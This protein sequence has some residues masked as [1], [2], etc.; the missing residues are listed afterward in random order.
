MIFSLGLFIL[1]MG[2]ALC[3]QPFPT[4]RRAMLTIHSQMTGPFPEKEPL[5]EPTFDDMKQVAFI[6]ANITEFLDVQPEKALTVASKHMG[7]L[8]ARNVPKLTEMMLQE[9]PQIRN[10]KMMMRAYMFLVD[11]LE[12]VVKETATMLKKNQESLRK[13]LEAAKKSEEALNSILQS[14]SNDL[15]SQEFLVYLDSEIEGQDAKSPMKSLLVTIKLRI[16]DEIGKSMGID[17]TILPK[18]AS[19]DSPSEL[20]RKTIMYLKSYNRQGKELFLQVLRITL[21]EMKQ[22]YQ[23]LDPILL[24]NLGE[25]EKLTIGLI[26]QEK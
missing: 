19:E 15:T 16:L 13:I 12:A 2:V 26:D 18:L 14:D 20:K 7:W 24:K 22:R 4:T 23:Q 25:I 9:F 17:V 1:A 10:D 11:F 5:L 21:L 6:L 8:Y 3:F